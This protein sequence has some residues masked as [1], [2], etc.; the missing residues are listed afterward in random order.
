MRAFPPLIK[1]RPNGATGVRADGVPNFGD[2]HLPLTVSG[3]LAAVNV[4]HGQGAP[5]R[6][7][8]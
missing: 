1:G 7:R 8:T 4:R 6:P 2:A 3:A 5:R